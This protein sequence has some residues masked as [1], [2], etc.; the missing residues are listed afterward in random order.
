MTEPRFVARTT[1]VK[2]ENLPTTIDQGTRQVQTFMKHQ[3][4]LDRLDVHELTQSLIDNYSRN[5]DT[6]IIASWLGR[7]K[8][9]GQQ[10]KLQAFNAV[11]REVREHSRNLQEYKAELLNREYIFPLIMQGQ[12][13]KAQQ[14]LELLRE[15][16]RTRMYNEQ[17]ERDI[18]FQKLRNSIL[19]NDSI[20]IINILRRK[21]A[22]EFDINNASPHATALIRDI[23]NPGMNSAELLHALAQY[24]SIKTDTDLKRTQVR[25]AEIVLDDTERKFNQ[26]WS[27]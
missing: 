18:L 9:E 10:K 13:L 21:I 15:Q 22:E 1:M 14:E 4:D 5:Q 25:T 27:K 23:L 12:L 26:K 3:V 24:E 8:F 11:V 2:T 7:K 20:E 6:G 16:H 19:Q 17:I